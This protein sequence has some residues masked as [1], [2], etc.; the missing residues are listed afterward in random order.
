VKIQK[1]ESAILMVSF[2][3]N[4]SLIANVKTISWY[5]W[6]PEEKYWS[7]SNYSETLEKILYVFERRKTLN[8]PFITD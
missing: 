3:N 7:F 2:T 4:P 6:Q 8:R 1:D 5:R